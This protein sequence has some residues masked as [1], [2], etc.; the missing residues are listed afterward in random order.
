MG[1]NSQRSIDVH[2]ERKDSVRLSLPMLNF[3]SDLHE[4]SWDPEN[5]SKEI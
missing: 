5:S 4:F 1:I 2:E 3:F